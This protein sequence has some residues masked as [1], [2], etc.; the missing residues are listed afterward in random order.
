MISSIFVPEQ[1]AGLVPKAGALSR[2]ALH[3]QP[4]CELRVCH[5]TPHVLSGGCPLTARWGR[6]RSVDTFG[7][8]R[9]IFG[10]ETKPNGYPKLDLSSSALGR[11]R[12]GRS[13][14]KLR[15]ALEAEEH[16]NGNTGFE[17][18]NLELLPAERAFELAHVYLALRRRF[19]GVVVDFVDFA[20][21]TM[22]Q[23]CVGAAYWYRNLFP[24]HHQGAS[25]PADVATE[26]IHAF[27]LERR[28][29][30]RDTL[31]PGDTTKTG[32]IELGGVLTDE[33]SYNELVEFW[34]TV[35]DRNRDGFR[36]LP[37]IEVSTAAYV[38]IHEFGHLVDAEL[39]SSSPRVQEKVYGHLSVALLGL[40]SMPSPQQWELNLL[41]YPTALA[42]SGPAGWGAKRAKLLK[43][44]LRVDISTSIGS[45]GLQSREEIFADS[46]ACAVGGPGRVLGTR[47]KLILG[48][49]RTAE[50]AAP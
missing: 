14:E 32:C 20:N 9:T 30:R 31:R 41:N 27:R 38:L 18:R 7:S 37:E 6:W 34:R 42:E 8:S 15:A 50:I 13:V 4:S 26:D 28:R 19:P 2:V 22:P 25:G 43:R 47:W 12:R 49:L 3:Q 5:E 33:D 11:Y 35:P 39:T 16:R 24:L 21:M 46:F 45:R 44:R 48:H 29:L 40:D 17:A 36:L 1:A 23:W 10:V